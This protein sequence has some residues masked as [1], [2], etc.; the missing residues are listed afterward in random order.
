MKVFKNR[1]VGMIK[2]SKII[3]LRVNL[4]ELEEREIFFTYLQKIIDHFYSVSRSL[5]HRRLLLEF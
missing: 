5:R 4:T 3:A 1:V 2:I